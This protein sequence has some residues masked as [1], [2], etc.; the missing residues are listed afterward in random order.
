MNRGL[1]LQGKSILVSGAAGRIGAAVVTALANEAAAVTACD[2][3]LQACTGACGAVAER[4]FELDVTQ[5]DHWD[6]ALNQVADQGGT[7][8][9]LVNCANVHIA[10]PITE[11]S[12]EDF[13]QQNEV[14]AI[15]SFRG[16]RAGVLAMRRSA[17]D[18]VPSGSIVNVTNLAG[19]IGVAN[20][21]G[22]AASAGAA[23]NMC[24]SMAVECGEAGEHI[25]INSVHAGVVRGDGNWID[26]N[27][28]SVPEIDP[29]EVAAT[30]LYLC[31][32]ESRLVTG[33]HFTVDG[34]L[35]SGLGI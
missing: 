9:A 11:L 16:V 33:S 27:L 14:N 6:R 12:L 32:D 1:R 15:G 25:R 29:D 17:A 34:G 8:D 18:G 13:R 2:K 22:I 7:I 10:A 20:G 19:H 4:C 30:V 26:S 23:K 5:E 21:V 35:S 24:K 31:S 28:R 3:D